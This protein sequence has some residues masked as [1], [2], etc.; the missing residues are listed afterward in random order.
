[1]VISRCHVH[2][3]AKLSSPPESNHFAVDNSSVRLANKQ[4]L[5]ATIIG[6]IVNVGEEMI[7]RGKPRVFEKDESM[8]L[9]GCNIDGVAYNLRDPRQIILG[10]G[11]EKREK[12]GDLHPGRGKADVPGSWLLAFSSWYGCV[13]GQ[14]GAFFSTWPWAVALPWARPLLFCHLAPAMK[15]DFVSR[16]RAD[17]VTST[18]MQSQ[19]ELQQKSCTHDQVFSWRDL[20]RTSISI[21]DLRGPFLLWSDSPDNNELPPTCYEPSS[22]GQNPHQGHAARVLGRIL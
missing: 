2:L 14:P 6:S 5:L 10:S 12:E 9:T 11:E 22:P 13:Q 21:L 15:R 20:N 3:T 19:I 7:K 17:R 1:M 18:K 4:A 16:T 8:T